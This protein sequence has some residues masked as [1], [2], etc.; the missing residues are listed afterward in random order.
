VGTRVT[1]R[2]E[3]SGD[4]REVFEVH[5]QAFE[6]DAEARLVELLR[7]EADPLISLV[8]VRGKR[9]VGHV[10]FTPVTVGGGLDRGRAMGLAPLAVL[11]EHQR[12]GIGTRLV[13]A[14]LEACRNLGR[15]VVFVLGHPEYY[16]RFGF[17]PAS[18]RGLRY[19]GAELGSFMVTGLGA[20]SLDGLSGSV[21]YHPAFDDV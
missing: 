21:R 19:Q 7:E 16:P 4:R 6:T 11:P 15:D 9:V 5:A 1:I 2:R 12:E 8:A 14:G 17:R 13:R 20:R 3:R 10:L 18:E